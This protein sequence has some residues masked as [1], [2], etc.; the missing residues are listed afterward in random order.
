MRVQTKQEIISKILSNREKILSFGVARL[1]MFGSFVRNEH[2]E[3]S[4]VD[5]LVEFKKGEKN[6][7]NL[8]DLHETL[9]DL[10]QRRVEV[11]T[12]EGLSKYFGHHILSETEY[13]LQSS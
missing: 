2:Q 9:H 8:F 11:V 3:D 7:R 1:G 10:T 6:Y 13:V 12:K 5:F 4:D